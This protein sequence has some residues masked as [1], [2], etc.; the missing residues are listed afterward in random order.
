M[1][2]RHQWSPSLVVIVAAALFAPIV[3]SIARAAPPPPAGTPH[4]APAPTQPS[5]MSPPPRMSPAPTS[6]LATSTGTGTTAA[7]GVGTPN[8]CGE[9]PNADRLKQELV[10]IIKQGKKA[11]TG[12]GNERWGAVVDRDGV[13]CAV[14]FSGA[15][16]GDQW[17]GSRVIA[18]EKANTANALS[19]PDFALSTA[20]LWASTQPGQS[21]FGLTTAAPPNAEAVFATEPDTLGTVAD[22]MIGKPIGG[23][24]VF[25]GGL[26][27]YNAKGKIVGGLG[28][29]GDTSCS[30]HVVAWKLRHALNLDA[31]PAGVAP[32]L[33]DNMILDVRNGV[34]P[35]GFGHPECIGGLPS[36]GAIVH[37]PAQFP[38]GPKP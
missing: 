25:G 35:S 22:P 33:T 24:I 34:S 7:P 14:V 20:N 6:S 32:N 19:G 31:V 30:D 11:N 5:H 26:A 37:L 23:V 21:L 18:A 1:Q 16:R 36:T 28:I 15:T 10:A 12:M 9:L 17:P 4:H 8:H 2:H 29:S 13:V 3:P 38:V 27:L